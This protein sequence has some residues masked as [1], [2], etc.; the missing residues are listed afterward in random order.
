MLVHVLPIGALLIGTALLLLGSG[1]LNTLL[2]IRAGLEEYSTET[3]GLI[4]SGYFMGFILGTFTALPLIHRIGHIRS[5]ALCAALV[6]A[7]ALLHTLVV[8]PWTWLGLRIITGVSLVTLY[9]VIES[10]LNRQTSDTHRGRVFSIYMVVNLGALAVAPQFLRL[11]SPM[12]YVLF[13]VA[14]ILISLS[15]VPITWTRMK[16]PEFTELTRLSFK[17]LIKIAPLAVVASFM[18]G[19]A[20]GAFW[21]LGP[22]YAEMIGLTNDD[23]ATFISFGILGGALFQFPVGRY[24]DNMDRR[25]VIA[26][27]C[28]LAVVAAGLLSLL[29]HEER[30]VLLAIAVYGGLAFSVYPVAIAHLVDHLDSDKVI[31][32]GS[33]LLVL[34]GV[35]AA[36]GPALVG[37]LMSLAG[38]AAVPLYFG[39]VHFL[40]GLYALIRLRVRKRDRLKHPSAFVPMVRTTPVALQLAPDESIGPDQMTA[41]ATS[42]TGEASAPKEP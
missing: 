2:A 8:E 22:V 42:S 9:T 15:L 32:G 29:S 23:I 16:Q 26:G 1:L 11:D 10:W 30:W 4:M 19:L 37:K 6:S 40:I 18:S 17:R 41:P 36:I 39:V 25:R 27:I 20:M 31:A 13:A 35:G 7:C 12:T 21:G 33:A 14:A 28:F 3:I 5:F 38:P 34:H 24:S